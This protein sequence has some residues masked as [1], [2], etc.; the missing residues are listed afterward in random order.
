FV[1]VHHSSPIGITGYYPTQHNA[2][3]VGESRSNATRQRAPVARPADGGRLRLSVG[4]GN[5]VIGETVSHATSHHTPNSYSVSTRLLSQPG[6]EELERTS[7]PKVISISPVAAKR[8]QIL[9]ARR[10][11]E[12]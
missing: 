8:H 3:P 7:R 11:P 5:T 10:V 12:N 1:V 6:L 9:A 2:A 4:A